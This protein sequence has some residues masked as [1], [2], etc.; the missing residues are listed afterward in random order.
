MIHR[1]IVTSFS[2]ILLSF[3]GLQAQTVLH[4]TGQ[5][6]VE[7][8]PT[9]TIVNFT[10]NHKA[11]SYETVLNKLNT[12]INGL[13]SSLKKQ[14]FK[15]EEIIT[16]QFNISKNRKY[17][18]GNWKED[19][20]T[21]NQQLLVVFAIDKDRL[22]KVLKATTG[23]GSQPDINISFAIDTATK[24]TTKETLLVR[25]V[26]NARKKADLIAM[27]TGQKVIGIQQINY[28]S[29]STSNPQPMYKMAEARLS[30]DASN[31]SPMEAESISMSDQVQI[32]YL[33][34]E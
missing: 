32:T 18:N 16:K 6:S 11:I 33:L 2:L 27:A 10:I 26:E 7:Q 8:K 9:E 3:L 1:K 31:F 25:A 20:Y 15:T 14:G 17:M 22:L 28:G 23:S 5:A 29:V 4:V 30:S 24:T 19:G 21:A 12:D 34:G 13:L